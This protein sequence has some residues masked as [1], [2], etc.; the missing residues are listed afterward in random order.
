MI[1]AAVWLAEQWAIIHSHTSDQHREYSYLRHRCTVQI[2][3]EPSLLRK[4]SKV[5]LATLATASS[6]SS[7]LK[8]HLRYYTPHPTTSDEGAGV[9]IAHQSINQYEGT[10]LLDFIIFHAGDLAFSSGPVS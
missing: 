8:V 10:Y 3:F 2:I 1:E 9:W 5:H 6:S 4:Q 7:N